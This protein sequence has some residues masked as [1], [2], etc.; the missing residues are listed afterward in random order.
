MVDPSES[1]RR[2]VLAYYARYAEESR[3]ASGHSLLEFERTKEI[4]A[5]VLPKPPARVLD[6]GGAAGVYS[7]WLAGQGYEVHLVDLSPRLVERRANGAPWHRSQSAM[8]ASCHS[9]M[10]G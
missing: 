3:L 7:F 6:V 2:D 5:R 9:P 10:V 4:L 8:P 1:A